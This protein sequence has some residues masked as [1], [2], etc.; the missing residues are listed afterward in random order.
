MSSCR[1]PILKNATTEPSGET[2]LGIR[3]LIRE[4]SSFGGPASSVPGSNGIS[5]GL[6]ELTRERNA[7]RR[8][9]VENDG[10]VAVACAPI[11]TGSGAPSAR[12]V[13]GSTAM[14]HRFMA[15]PRSLAK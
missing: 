11:V 12:P 10:S 9:S 8:P 4:S 2:S 6:I 15:P 7:S 1:S 5:N 13:A 3:T 14:R